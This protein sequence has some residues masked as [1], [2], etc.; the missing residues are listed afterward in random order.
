[1]SAFHPKRT[2]G[3]KLPEAAKPKKA[4]NRVVWFHHGGG[5]G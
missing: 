1:M 4:A 5:I 2:F 3:L